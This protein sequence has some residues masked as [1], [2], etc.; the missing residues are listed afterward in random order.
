[1][2]TLRPRRLEQGM[3]H[4]RNEVIG[5]CEMFCRSCKPHASPKEAHNLNC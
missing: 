1:M 3:G 5:I 4:H 2:Q